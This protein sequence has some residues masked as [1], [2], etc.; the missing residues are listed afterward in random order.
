MNWLA[1]PIIE[2]RTGVSMRF[3]DMQLTEALLIPGLIVLAV[4]CGFF[5]AI[6]AYRT[7]VAR[8]L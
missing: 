4:I 3:W 2:S 6:S 8:S 1:S 7:D 5:P